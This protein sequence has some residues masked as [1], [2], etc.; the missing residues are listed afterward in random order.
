MHD[1]FAN[2]MYLHAFVLNTNLISLKLELCSETEVD[3]QSQRLRLHSNTLILGRKEGGC[4]AV[5]K[6]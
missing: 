3:I 1:N 4:K 2:H 6:F 5:P